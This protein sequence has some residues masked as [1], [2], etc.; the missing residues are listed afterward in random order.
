MT[1]SQT[2]QETVNIAFNAGLI[3]GWNEAIEARA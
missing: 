2:P 3:E 1:P